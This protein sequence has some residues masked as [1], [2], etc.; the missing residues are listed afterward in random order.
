MI[1]ML[2]GAATPP[3][4]LLDTPLSGI[5]K[6]HNTEVKMLK[7]KAD[8]CIGLKVTI[9]NF[10]HFITGS[11]PYCTDCTDGSANDGRIFISSFLHGP[12]FARPHRGNPKKYS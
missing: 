3:F 7:Q 9:R 8:L 11:I 4:H 12:C 5:V 1:G 2:L 10:N 6:K